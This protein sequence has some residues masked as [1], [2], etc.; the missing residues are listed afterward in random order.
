M[1]I[2]ISEEIGIQFGSQKVILNYK[3]AWELYHCLKERLELRH[4]DPRLDTGMTTPC[5]PVL[6]DSGT[7]PEKPWSILH[8]PV[9]AG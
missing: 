1:T 3:E 4:F 7:A 6:S 9:G 5:G 8:N 2:A